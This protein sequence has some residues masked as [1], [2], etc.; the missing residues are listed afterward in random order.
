MCGRI[1]RRVV[2]R[3]QIVLEARSNPTTG[4]VQRF[5]NV[6]DQF[7]TQ[8]A[9]GAV[10]F[11][12]NPESVALMRLGDALI[13]YPGIERNRPHSTK[14]DHD[15]TSSG[16]QDRKDASRDGKECV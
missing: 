6:G 10:D 4:V 13:D 1:M 11:P 16:C 8:C 2:E 14:T 5:L 15:C 7:D 3:R 12:P 9:E